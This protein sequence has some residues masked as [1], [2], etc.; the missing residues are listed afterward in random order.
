MAKSEDFNQE[1]FKL[2][3][4]VGHQIEFLS[5]NPV[6]YSQAIT[7][8]SKCETIRIEGK[9]FVPESSE[10]LPAVIIVPGSLGVSDNHVSHAETL[11]S[12]GIAAFVIDP[13]T[14]RNVQST[15]ENQTHYSF[16][17]SAFDVLAALRVLCEYPNVDANRI[18]AQG[19]SRGGSA[20]LTAAVRTFADAIV[21]PKYTFKG[22]YAVYPW[23]GHQFLRP[24]T[25]LTR[26][27][28]I[29]G[30]RDDWL[31]VQQVQSQIQAIKLSGGSSSIRIVEG[32]SHSFDR[33]EDLHQIPEASVTPQAP[34]IYLNSN[35]A[36]IDPRSGDADPTATDRTHF[37]ASVEAGFGRRGAH[38]GG[39]EEEQGIFREDM[40]A[41]HKSNL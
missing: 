31:S 38:I 27:R 3:G 5:A 20:V 4:V 37:V 15:V 34:T 36:M 16:A 26:V 21:G 7:D 17:A 25:G 6:N 24:D 8:T 22:I 2:S 39:T 18:S 14:K 19:H 40:L 1:Q 10:P 23:C 29:I 11:I 33:E 32:A 28:A 41:F 35:G 9:L 13:F 30:E 12:E